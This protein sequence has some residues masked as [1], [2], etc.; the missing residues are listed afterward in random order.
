MVNGWAEA[1]DGRPDN[2][3]STLEGEE[4]EQHPALRLQT[5]APGG[6]P[7]RP[8]TGRAR[9]T[10]R[11]RPA[12]VTGTRARTRRLQVAPD[13]PDP[14]PQDLAGIRCW[15]EEAAAM[16]APHCHDDLEMVLVE[17]DEP[18]YYHHRDQL[19][20]LQPGEVT[21]FWAAFPH[22][23]AQRSSGRV[24][25]RLM[26]PMGLLLSRNLPESLLAALLAG[27]VLV[28]PVDLDVV[29]AR[30]SQWEIDVRSGDPEIAKA[31][32]LEIEGWIRRLMR[33]LRDTAVP[34]STERSVTPRTLDAVA[35]MCHHLVLHFREP[36][37]VADVAR[38]ASIH[39]QH[40]MALF[41]ETIGTTIGDYLT[42]CRVSEAQRLLVATSATTTDIAFASGFGS[43]S[44]FYECFTSRCGR[45]PR[46]YRIQMRC[47]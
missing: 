26:V 5:V 18:A 10:R 2:V 7:E 13:R 47:S 32:L 11:E 3:D 46:E 34:S 16:A 45:T 25:D 43:V 12:G 31:T 35:T 29:S 42:G 1:V 14:G 30:F 38:A 6:L 19:I 15:R 27:R 9:T 44:Q 4:V 20:C 33:G 37:Q 36:L 8:R 40:A 39:P 41:R 21:A 28:G 22:T 24:L 23:L 17:G